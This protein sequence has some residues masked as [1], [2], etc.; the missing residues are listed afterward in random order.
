MLKLLKNSRTLAVPVPYFFAFV[1]AVS[2]THTPHP[3]HMLPWSTVK[4]P[5]SFF[6]LVALHSEMLNSRSWIVLKTI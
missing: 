1:F 6:K 5:I 3:V 4:A 2:R